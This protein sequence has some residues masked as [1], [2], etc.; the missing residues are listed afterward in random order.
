[1][2]AFMVV[3]WFGLAMPQFMMGVNSKEFFHMGI[4]LLMLAVSGM[5]AVSLV[6]ELKGK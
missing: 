6:R 3:W 4:G 5:N 1:M 2:N